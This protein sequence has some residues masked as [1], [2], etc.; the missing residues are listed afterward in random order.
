MIGNPEYV[1]TT[2]DVEFFE[3]LESRKWSI[4]YFA[5]GACRYSAAKKQIPGGNLDTRGWTLEEYKELIHE[6]QGK[7]IRIVE[8]IYEEG[9]ISL[10]RQSLEVARES[11]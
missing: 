11:E 9:A 7:D 1:P 3:M 10:L 2:D 5:P 6:L 8:S 4:V